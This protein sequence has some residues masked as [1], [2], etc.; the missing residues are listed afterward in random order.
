MGRL[1]LERCGLLALPQLVLSVLTVSLLLGYLLSLRRGEISPRQRPWA[2]TLEPLAGISTTVGLLG[3][4]VGFIVA[5]AGFDNG[6]DVP[7][8][9]RGLSTAYWTTGVGIVTAL[10]ASAGAYLLD[11][12]HKPEVQL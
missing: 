1:I 9:T 2:R 8:L 5:F 11:A 4:V 6:V 10:V 12:L 7:R 3:S